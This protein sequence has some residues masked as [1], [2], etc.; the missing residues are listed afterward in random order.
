MQEDKN[1]MEAIQF[2]Y[3]SI[4]KNLTWHLV[5]FPNKRKMIIIKWVYKVK[6]KYENTLDKYKTWL[7]EKVFSQVKGI[8]FS[9]TSTPAMRMHT[10]MMIM[11]V[12]VEEWWSMS[13]MDTKFRFDKRN[14]KE[15]V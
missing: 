13:K 8:Y 15:E 4:T 6:Y 1:G 10:L 14:L 3:N 5:D 2:E 11:D 9:K 12:V 7:M